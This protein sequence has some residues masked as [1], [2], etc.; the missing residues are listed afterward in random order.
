MDK[1]FKAYSLNLVTW[2]K[3]NDFKI[4][5]AEKINGKT[6]FYFE[7]TQELY[8]C[9]EEYN[10]NEELKKFISTFKEIRQL[11]KTLN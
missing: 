8:D 4:A 6:S 5:K 2:L 9:I 7:S 10:N 3:M 1:Y 11:T